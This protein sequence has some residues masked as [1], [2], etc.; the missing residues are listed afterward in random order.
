MTE[1]RGAWVVV[2]SVVELERRQRL[3]VT[4]EPDDIVVWWYDGRPH[5]LRNICIHE[6]R[7]L[8]AGSLLGSRVVCPGHQWAFE[9]ETGYCRERD[10][11]QP[12]Y[13]TKV[14]GGQILVQVPTA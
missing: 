8:A 5:A 4:A 14:E 12:V 3:V 9:L 6:Q 7:E 11:A 1:D 2:G 10:R 13:R